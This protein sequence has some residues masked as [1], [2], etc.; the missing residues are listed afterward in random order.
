MYLRMRWYS[1]CLYSA[2]QI[3]RCAWA[4]HLPI[5]SAASGLKSDLQIYRYST[6]LLRYH[7]S[8][9][10]GA[11]NN[12]VKYHRRPNCRVDG[13]YCVWSQ[14]GYVDITSRIYS[15]WSSIME[16]SCFSIYSFHLIAL[17]YM[18]YTAI[19]S[20]YCSSNEI[21]GIW[22]SHTWGVYCSI[23]RGCKRW[24]WWVNGSIHVQ[25]VYLE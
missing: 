12:E 5:K 15:F 20:W 18:F 14:N 6:L 1:H 24:R 7:I 3:M 22:G 2:L 17:D 10:V 25:V 23:Q 11:I 16:I 9:S 8:S 21:W 19:F 4:K 13:S